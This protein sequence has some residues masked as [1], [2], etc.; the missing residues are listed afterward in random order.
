[1][2]T[3]YKIKYLREEQGMTQQEL[4]KKSGVSRTIISELESGKR[5]VTRTDT[6]LKISKALKHPIKDIFL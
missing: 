1:M 6:L 4:S 3:A 5:S 2:T